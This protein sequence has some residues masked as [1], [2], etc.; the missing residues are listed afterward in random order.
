MA[1]SPRGS[2]PLTELLGALA[3]PAALLGAEGN[4]QWG[5]PAL[6]ELFSGTRP[7]ASLTEWEGNSPPG[8]EPLWPELQR[9]RSVVRRLATASG[10]MSLRLSLV[11][12]V[13]GDPVLVCREADGARLDGPRGLQE[14][15]ERTSI[16]ETIF[17]SLN[18]GV[19]AI[20]AAERI[21]AMSLSAERMTGFAEA[22]VLGRVCHDVFQAPVG[23]ECPFQTMLRKGESFHQRDMHLFGKNGRSIHV[24]ANATMLK[25]ADGKVE[26][27]LVVLKDLSE[28]DRLREGLR[29]GAGFHG[30]VGMHPLLRR[31]T[32]KIEMVAPS[33]VSILIQGESGTGKELVA[34]AI[35]DLSARADG[36]FIKV[37][38]AA[39]SEHLLESELFG[40]VR[41]AFTGAVK[42]RP[43]R[44]EVAHQGTL[45]LD[46]IGETSPGLQVKL[47]RVLQEGE[48]ERV[49]ESR[50]RKADVRILAATN[51][52]LRR[53]VAAGRFRDDLFYR[54]CVVP[55]E[56]PPLRDRA[57][58]IPLL[59]DHFL[60]R[61]A[62]R[63]GR[64]KVLSPSNH[65][66]L[67]RYRWPGNVRELENALAH[68]Y[69]CSAGDV[70]SAESL[71][72]H[73]LHGEDLFLDAPAQ[74][75]ERRAI[76]AA[77]EATSWNKGEA[78]TRLGL[79]RTTLWRRMR[80]LGIRQPRRSPRG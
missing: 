11:S 2:P 60:K 39:L 72:E 66:L 38:C 75:E 16:L 67:Q 40:H 24:S 6:G 32:E 29:E 13:A 7:P 31:V 45:F 69:V 79:S 22:E 25:T 80:D 14:L 36:P 52:D 26:G 23:T 58:D 28:M 19:L 20:D 1:C 3:Q 30:I 55:I 42:D 44:F 57:D 12:S 47:L 56:L 41:G 5:N 61:L 77:L 65:G 4:I 37:N 21:I 49:G 76:V 15:R 70:I 68:A 73:I 74:G 34:K 59:A 35:H 10:V 18:E 62:S 71:P 63:E 53:E 48:F 27:A 50:T 8:D 43:G 33:E 17:H 46:E 51:K 78:A 64:R 54:L 9:R